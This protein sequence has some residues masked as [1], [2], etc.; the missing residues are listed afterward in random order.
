MDDLARPPVQSSR[1]TLRQDRKVT[2]SPIPSEDIA[3]TKAL[4]E[5]GQ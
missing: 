2:E 3:G 4:Q 5:W 1:Q